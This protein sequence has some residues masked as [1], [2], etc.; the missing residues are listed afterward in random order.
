MTRV[1]LMKICQ[2]DHRVILLCKL[3]EILLKI[4]LNEI[5]KFLYQNDHTDEYTWKEHID[6]RI[7][8]VNTR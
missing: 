4:K 8:S 7:P 3:C 1:E 2:N 6:N 5:L